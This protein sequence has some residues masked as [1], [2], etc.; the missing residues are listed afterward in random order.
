MSISIIALL[1]YFIFLVAFAIYSSFAVY[2][3]LQFC[4]IGDL[5]KPISVIYVIVSSA[6][7]VLTLAFVFINIINTR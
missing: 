6:I 7:V 1:V 2:H 3:L 5:C 4:Q